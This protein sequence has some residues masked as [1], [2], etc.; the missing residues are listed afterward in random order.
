[1]S[2]NREH[3]GGGLVGASLLIGAG[4]IILLNNLGWLDWNVW[5]VL[6]GL[7]PL[8]LVA[9][10]L[11]LLIGR[12]SLLGA[13]VAAI[14]VLGMFG[15]VI[16]YATTYPLPRT[17]EQQDVTYPLPDAEQA[18]IILDPAV[19]N[20]RVAGASDFGQ[21]LQGTIFTQRG[22]HLIA[23]FSEHGEEARLSLSSSGS[24]MMPFGVGLMAPNWDL[25][26]SEDLPLALSVDFGA[27]DLDLD[28]ANVQLERLDVDVGVGD[29]TVWLPRAGR[30]SAN[31]E[32]AIGQLTVIL[33]SGLE[34][35]ID[36]DTALG[37][38]DVPGGFSR[39]EGVYVSPGYEGAD[40]RVQ[41]HVGLAIGQVV[42]RYGGR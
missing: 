41:L 4:V 19:G 26:V 35:R 42:V 17:G 9:A 32:G 38:V 5:D 22:E 14:L 30:Y 28:L 25:K 18:Q 2:E 34:A 40:N 33:P 20:V 31:L 15:G 27:G 36:T 7:W 12:R 8:L 24:F 23:D 13:L 3:R 10:G 16:W 37:T 29:V 11:D 6:V 21:L 1:M 39:S